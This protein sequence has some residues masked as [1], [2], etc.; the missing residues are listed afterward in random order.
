[1]CDLRNEMSANPKAFKC[2]SL[3]ESLIGIPF[4]K[5]PPFIASKEVVSVTALRILADGVSVFLTYYITLFLRLKAFPVLFPSFFSPIP[6]KFVD[7]FSGDYLLFLGVLCLSLLLVNAYN[8]LYDVFHLQKRPLLWLYFVSNL[9]IFLLLVL[10][11]WFD[12]N[13]WHMRSFYVIFFFL[14]PTI[15][16][17]IRSSL[18]KVLMDIRKKT[19]RLLFRSVLVGNDAAAQ[20]ILKKSKEFRLSN[21]TIVRHLEGFSSPEEIREKLPPILQQEK[22]SFIFFLM[23]PNDALSTEIINVAAAHHIGV[24]LPM[25]AYF[26]IVN[27]FS[28]NDFIK[29][30]ALLHFNPLVF[31]V[32]ESRIRAV[33][34]RIAAAVALLVLSP[35]FL[36]VAILIKL[37]SKGPVFFFQERYGK[38]C[39]RFRMCKFRTMCNDAESKLESLRCKNETDGALFKMKDDPRVT[40]VGRLLRTTSLDELPQL[41]NIF[42]GEMRFVGPRPLPC[43]DLD[44]YLEKWQIKRQLVAPGLTCIWQTCGRSDIGFDIMAVLDIWYAHNRTFWLDCHIILRTFYTVLFCRGS[45]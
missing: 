12:K 42:R 33:L 35:L 37:D 41:I 39:K 32:A 26:N 14:N 28:Y 31:G 44:P 17:I 10:W 1:M 43:R 23:K 30:K 25:P 18:N 11:L 21:Y 20:K 36:L 3:F 34:E 2:P 4:S 38:D 6:E 13:Y 15:S 45:Y 40:K 19:G 24:L 27:P 9:F 16:C 7:Y 29:G 5:V 22:A 8:G